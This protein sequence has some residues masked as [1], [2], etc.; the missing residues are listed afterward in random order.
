MKQKVRSVEIHVR[1]R[2]PGLNELFLFSRALKGSLTSVSV[3]S[4]VTLEMM[5]LT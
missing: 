2:S 3:D 5:K 1:I 4:R